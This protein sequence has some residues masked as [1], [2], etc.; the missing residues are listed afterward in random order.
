MSTICLI[1]A[2]DQLVVITDR[3]FS[4]WSGGDRTELN[5]GTEWISSG[6]VLKKKCYVRLT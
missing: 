2:E 3:Y 1:T 4:L 6:Q 5:E